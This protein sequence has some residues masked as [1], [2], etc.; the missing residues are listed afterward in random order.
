MTATAPTHPLMR[1]YV[2]TFDADDEFVREIR[3][4][5]GSSAE[6]AQLANS[7]LT[8]EEHRIEVPLPFVPTGAA[9]RAPASPR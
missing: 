7:D 2:K 3:V 9:R 4:E 1:Y 5:A 8:S 6:A